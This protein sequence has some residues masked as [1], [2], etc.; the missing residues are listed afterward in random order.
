M[1]GS[2]PGPRSLA[3]DLAAPV[4]RGRIGFWSM[5]PSEQPLLRR[6]GVDGA[7]PQVSSG[8]VLALTTQN[9]GNNKIDAYLH[10][11]VNDH[12]IVDPGS[13]SVA[14]QVTV[15]LR[16]DATNTGLPPVVIDSSAYPDLPAG[17]NRTWLTV[18]SPMDLNGLTIDGHSASATSGPEFGIHAYSVYVNIPPSGEST[19]A[20]S[21]KGQ[22]KPTGAY[23]LDLRLQPSVNPITS[24]V[25]V[26]AEGDWLVAGTSRSTDD[27]TPGPSERQHLEVSFVH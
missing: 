26:E 19:V 21:L 3:Q 11:T 24:D 4:A 27:W 9:A 17:T 10:T 8:D 1:Q 14:S 12:V 23:R 15:T 5:H 7:F 25:R 13:G 6:I 18:Y 22:V 2:L 20:L 16:N